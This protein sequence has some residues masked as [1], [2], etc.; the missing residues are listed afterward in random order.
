MATFRLQPPAP[1]S[2]KCPDKWAKWK[3]R[4]EQFQAASGLS[5]EAEAKQVNTLLYSM[6]EDAEDTLASMNS[7][8]E[9]RATYGRVI[10]KFDEFFKVRKNV[11]YERAR[12]NKQVQGEDESVEQFIASL[13]SLADRCDF[14]TP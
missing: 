4:F 1:F 5:G 13:Y 11:I 3:R 14:D 9:E 6:G 10:E 12:F 7:S 8:E 2:F